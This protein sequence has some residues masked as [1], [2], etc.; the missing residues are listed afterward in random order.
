MDRH[1]DLETIIAARRACRESGQELLTPRAAAELF[2]VTAAAVRM[3]RKHGELQPYLRMSITGKAVELTLLGTAL[4][5]WSKRPGDFASKLEAYRRNGITVV[6][7]NAFF[8]ILHSE[9]VM[10]YPKDFL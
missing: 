8:N 5:Y 3:A 9:T 7:D 6:V 4:Q 10:T 2:E 1:R